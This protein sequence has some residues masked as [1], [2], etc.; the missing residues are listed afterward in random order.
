MGYRFPFKFFDEQ[1][2]DIN[3][4]GNKQEQGPEQ[5]RGQ[6]CEEADFA[7][8]LMFENK[9]QDGGEHGYHITCP[10]RYT[11]YREVHTP[12][13]GGVIAE[14]GTER[15]KYE[16]QYPQGDAYD[17]E[18]H[19]LYCHVVSGHEVAF[20]V[21]IL[22]AG[23]Y[24]AYELFETREEYVHMTFA[25]AHA[26]SHHY[27]ECSGLFVIEHSFVAVNYLVSVSYLIG[28]KL[29]VFRESNVLPAVRNEFARHQVTGTRY[30]G[31]AAANGTASGLIAAHGEKEDPVKTGHGVL[32]EIF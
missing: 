28:G 29:P 15:D 19:D 6:C 18:R 17:A 13:G 23:E 2:G 24:A 4:Y 14:Q 16:L 21:L 11:E 26:L 22:F 27:F 5:E 25:P 3:E 31:G 1:H 30:A 9:E 8:A 7:Y 12:H 20:L 32:T 10:E